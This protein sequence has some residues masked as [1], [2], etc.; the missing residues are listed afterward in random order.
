MRKL[1]LLMLFIV[2]SIFLWAQVRT[3]TGK[4]TNEKGEPVANATVKEVGNGKNVVEADENGNFS[5]KVKANAKLTV[6]YNEYTAYSFTPVDGLNTV[7][8]KGSS[9][10]KLDEVLINTAL[11]SKKQK[12]ELGYA[13]TQVSAS[14]LMKGKATN[15]GS[16]L[17]GKVA[18]L[19]ITTP[20]SGVDNDV[21]L[22]LRGNRSLRGN[23]QPILVLDG[24]VVPISYINS[25]NANDIE[26]I[27]ILKGAG[28][29]AVYGNEAS[30]GALIVTTKKG[31]KG[32]STINFSSSLTVEQ[33]SFMPKMQ[34]QFGSNG[35]EAV[36]STGNPLYIPYENQSYGPKYDG[37]MVRL[38]LPVRV[39][40]ATGN[41]HYDSLMVPYS[42]R[43][44][45]KRN[46]FKDATTFQNDISFSHADL[47]G[48]QFFVSLQNL[49]RNGVVPNDV[50]KRN[51]VRVSASKEINKFTLA[52]NVSYAKSNTDVVGLSERDEPLYM[53]VLQTPAHVPLTQ[54]Q[55]VVNNPFATQSGYFNAYYGNPYWTIQ[56][57]RNKTWKDDIL[58]NVDFTYKATKWL[59]AS[60]KISY[61]GDY[62]TYEVFR[63]GMQYDSWLAEDA[64][65]FDPFGGAAGTKFQGTKIA[66]H[67]FRG[68][69]T[70]SRLQ[71]DFLLK[72][73]HDFSSDFGAVLL[74]GATANESQYKV[75]ESG[76]DVNGTINDYD[77]LGSIWGPATAVGNPL[78][79]FDQTLQRSTGMFADL[80]LKY[81]NY[82]FLHTSVRRDADSR[83]EPAN[84]VFVYPA[85]DL[86]FLFSE[87]IPAV[88]NFAPLNSGKIRVSVA[89]VGNIS[90]GPYSTRNTYSAATGYGFP[91]TSSTGTINGYQLSTAF[92]N[93]NL[94]PEF[95]TEKELGLELVWLKNRLTTDFSFYQQ[96]TTNQTLYANIS[97]AT[98]GGNM[99]Q[100]IGETQNTGYEMAI[101]GII[102]QT[103][104]V[105]WS[106]GFNFSHNDNKVVS[107]TP[108]ITQLALNTDGTESGTSGLGGG[109]YA[110]TGGVYPTLQTTDWIRDPATGKIIVDSKTGTPTKSSTIKSFGTTVAPDMLGLN[111]SVSYGNFSLSAVAEYRHGA[112]LMNS[113]APNMDFAGISENSVKYNRQPFILPN[114]EY[115]NSNGQYVANTN[116]YTN[117][118]SGAVSNNINFF[119]NL[120]NQVGSN[121]V[122]SADF[123]KLREVSISYEI[124]TKL[125]G[126]T[127]FIRGGNVS[128][129]GRDLLMI[130]PKEN[131]WTDPEFNNATASKHN[132]SGSTANASSGNGT[133]ITSLD[134]TPS[135]RKFGVALNLTF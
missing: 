65:I 75:T 11:G 113:M 60:Y 49:Q 96:N 88:K 102:V 132:A 2:P 17:N 70:T 63:N 68:A 80:S 114:S 125:L 32:K 117:T 48:G 20:N 129:F 104:K 1:V 110:I 51:T 135:T 130:L 54:L 4:V 115:M 69:S 38:G 67:G 7:T 90:V 93:P 64:A 46:F 34:N 106:L 59:T 9:A 73:T 14:E 77:N 56:N 25:I 29:T 94:A 24:S 84:R 43:P 98:G 127:K 36:D 89:K 47:N 85:A 3:V 76:R 87:A 107:I 42:A 8:L 128:I 116:V 6:S 61:S 66:P 101:K 45:E 134:Q 81:R 124:P 111:S 44:D 21:R 37:H 95:T 22:V 39:F 82:L 62:Q 112:V 31:A 57:S 100:N 19:T 121:Y 40:D 74:L 99:L 10:Q 55:D 105:Q 108:N 27:N 72:A 12:K 83:L 13:T 131:M 103:R 126:K 18:G 41:Y 91:Y 58:A 71:G 5:I 50:F 123:W 16:A 92:N 53:S 118:G 15:I 26:S 119:A 30:N 97:Y 52:F 79:Y 33:V 78:S 35:G 133:G 109:V 122:T 120:Y 86:S 28:A 23:N